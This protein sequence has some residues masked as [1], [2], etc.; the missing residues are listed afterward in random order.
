MSLE[1]LPH[2][3]FSG[4][5]LL[6]I[7]MPMGG[8]G[9]GCICL[10][11]YGG[12]QDFSIRHKPATTALPDSWEG[13]D[14]AFALL[15]IK[16][17]KPQT[18]LVEGPLPIERIYDQSLQ[19]QGLRQGGSEGLPRFEN[20]VFENQYPFGRVRLDDETV[21]L[22]VTITGW[23]PFIPLD[24]VNSSLPCAIAE[25][26]LTNTSDTAV[27]FE[28][29]YHLSHLSAKTKNHAES[30]NTPI[31]G[32]FGGGLHFTNA[33]PKDSEEFGSASLFFVGHQPK[34]KAMWFR[35][36]WFD[37]LSVLW[38]EVS[39]GTFEENDGTGEPD[40]GRNGGSLLVSA[41]LEPNE[42]VTIPVLIAWYFPNSNLRAGEAK[43]DE[44][45]VV[46]IPA[47]RP[48]YAG[49]WADAEA[50]A[51]YVAQHYADLRGRTENFAKALWGSTLPLYVVD[52]VASNLAILKSP[53]V[54]RQENGNLW[55]WEG[56]FTERGS[57]HGSC[58]HVWNYAQALPHLFPSLERTLRESELVRSMDER[59]HVQFRSA[60]PDGPTPHDYH[61]AADGQLGGI[62]KIYR[63][64]HI[65]GDKNWLEAMY[66]LAKRSLDYCIESWDPQRR[67]GLFE[68]HHNTYDIEFWGPDGM[69]G[70]IY[71]GALAALTEL[72]RELGRDEEAV[73]YAELLQ[74]AASF[75]DEKLFNGE[76]YRQNVQWE[77]LRD[78]SFTERMA[79]VDEGSSAALRLEKAEGPK[80]QYG[81]GCLSDGIIGQWM[82]QLYGVETSLNRQNVRSA[83][84]AI[85]NHNF[86]PNL[87]NHASTQ[88]PGYAMGHEAGLVLCTWPHDDKPTLPFVYCDEIW[89]GI[90]YQVASHLILEGLVE[91][92]LT[93]VKA[94]RSRY[95]GRV[96]NPFNEYECGSYYARAL[97][98]YALLNSLSGF[99]YDA[100]SQTLS[101]GPKIESEGPFCS[102]F[103]TANGYGTI[104]LQNDSLAVILL[105]G[106]LPIKTLLVTDNG[107]TNRIEWGTT[108]RSGESATVRF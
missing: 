67:G 56:C 9:A 15:H 104:E 98:S 84:L 97:A 79:K 33:Q 64:Y 100:V 68:P 71:V 80:Y 23:S 8:I 10:N 12:F 6:Q 101:F 19:A 40:T 48:F 96:R 53:T 2:R 7:A 42:T 82:A 57:C 70:S 105:E 46:S 20:S 55:A 14:A 102:F 21:P 52:A 63:D 75:L 38:R 47:W 36:G 51:R 44:N 26:T 78:T 72:A 61:A 22:S 58:T 86:K 106:E 45:E 74:R 11:G 43:R 73:P 83:L 95:E 89:T 94:A 92:G 13:L 54:L 24:D 88:R 50:V 93:I 16:G 27:E 77:G 59:G 3:P 85:F 91:E 66:P 62:L 81:S 108:V 90:E 30:F 65:C 107:K 87:W 35:G 41:S 49:Q 5:N 28:F 37:G 69:C 103:S 99:Q 4:V 76:Y 29:S 60:L 25:Y 17:E 34:T 1:S 18:R 39:T 31:S 32:D